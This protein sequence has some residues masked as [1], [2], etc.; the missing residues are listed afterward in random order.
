MMVQATAAQPAARELT[1]EDLRAILPHRFPFL[2]LDKVVDLVPGKSAAGLKNVSGNEI[3][4]LGHFPSVAIMP[5]ALIVEAL[6]QTLHVLDFTSRNI[7]AEQYASA[8]MYLG[9][10]NITFARPVVP[11]DQLRLEVEIVKLMRQGVIGKAVARV[12]AEVAAKGE[13][14]LILKGAA[15]HE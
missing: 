4:F 12:G 3:H 5:G 10:V 7:P 1:F 6:A 15:A 11:G 2:M 13:I 9:S 14:V 8:D